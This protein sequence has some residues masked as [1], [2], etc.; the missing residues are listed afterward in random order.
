M[1]GTRARLLTALLAL[2]SLSACLGFDSCGS[3]NAPTDVPA[4]AVLTLAAN[5]DAIT[6][7]SGTSTITVTGVSGGS[8]LAAGIVV[9]FSTTLGTIDQTV[10]LGSGGV[11]ATTLRGDGRAGI[12]TVT[13]TAGSATAT[14]SVRITG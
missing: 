5:P 11:A 9:S 4:G 7:L 8:P 12:A 6:S 14:L 3:T 2:G 1:N 13:A 10:Q